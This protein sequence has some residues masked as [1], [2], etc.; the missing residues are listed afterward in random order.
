MITEHEKFVRKA[1]GIANGT[2]IPPKVVEFIDKAEKLMV[3]AHVSN[4]QKASVVG[5]LGLYAHL[6]PEDFK[7][8]EKQDET[9]PVSDADDV[10]GAP[11]SKRSGKK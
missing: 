9:A 10:S 8:V 3:K 5:L 2:P 4:F 1:L 7:I 6:R 11:Q